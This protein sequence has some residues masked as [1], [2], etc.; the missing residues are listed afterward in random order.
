MHLKQVHVIK[1]VAD[2]SLAKPQRPAVENTRN[3]VLRLHGHQVG[4]AEVRAVGDA[5]AACQAREVDLPAAT[6]GLRR[7]S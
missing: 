4:V 7:I 3:L 5:G 6:Q 2:A 1:R